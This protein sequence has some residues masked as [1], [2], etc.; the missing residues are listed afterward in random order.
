M[1]PT[2]DQQQLFET[3]KLYG[4]TAPHEAGSE[5]SRTAAIMAEPSRQT[6]MAKVLGFIKER[7]AYGATDSEIEVGLGMLHQTASARRRDLELLE[8]IVFA[9]RHRL[10]ASKRPAKVWVAK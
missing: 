9:G 4:G 6:K 1:K 5:T 2:P 8:E 7:G 3:G 10:T